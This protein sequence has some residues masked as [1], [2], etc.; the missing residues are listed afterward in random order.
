MGP[1]GADLALCSLHQGP[2]LIPTDGTLHVKQSATS[3]PNQINLNSDARVW[4]LENIS[5]AGLSGFLAF[6]STFALLRLIGG[7][8]PPEALFGAAE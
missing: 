5:P 2:R 1:P 8:G 7:F 6:S 4:L 3:R